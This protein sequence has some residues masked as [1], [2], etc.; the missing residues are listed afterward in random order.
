MDRLSSVWHCKFTPMSYTASSFLPLPFPFSPPTYT[1][2]H[3]CTWTTTHS[4]Q[5]RSL[6]TLR[7]FA[8]VDCQWE[9]ASGVS[10]IPRNPQAAYE[11][12]KSAT[13]RSVAELL[14][15]VI[16]G[17][18]PKELGICCEWARLFPLST[19][20]STNT[21]DRVAPSPRAWD[22]PAGIN[23]TAW[24]LSLSPRVMVSEPNQIIGFDFCSSCGRK[25][26][27]ARAAEKK[28][29]KSLAS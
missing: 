7:T 28:M 10:T 3:L 21:S 15:D 24:A 25:M 27:Q 9:F 5:I 12:S 26:L 11:F 20:D 17:G 14:A 6:Y 8:A 2:T 4:S 19:S 23:R 18:E 29:W 16:S 22:V 1:Y 13:I